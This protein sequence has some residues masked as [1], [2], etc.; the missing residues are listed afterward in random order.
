[1][2]KKINI[3]NSIFSRPFSFEAVISQQEMSIFYSFFVIQLSFNKFSSYGRDQGDQIG[4]FLPIE[5][6]ILDTNVEKQLL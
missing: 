1:M 5:Q 4:Q 2:N 6:H 3:K